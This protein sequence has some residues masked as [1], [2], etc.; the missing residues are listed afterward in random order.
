[1]DIFYDLVNK[2]SLGQKSDLKY[3]KRTKLVF[4]ESEFCFVRF[5]HLIIDLKGLI[6]KIFK[7]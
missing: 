1:M 7:N 3:K 2:K 4:W 5:S 6:I